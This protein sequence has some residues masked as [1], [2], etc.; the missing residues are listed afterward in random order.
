MKILVVAAVPNELK[1]IKE[2]IKSAGLKKNLNIDYLCCGIWNYETISSLERYLAENIEPVFIF[3][4]WICGYWSQD[5]E[6]KSEPIQVASV[7]NIYT[8]KELIIPPFLQLASLKTCF[9]WENLFFKKTRSDIV[10]WNINN[11]VYFDT[12]SWWI[13]FVASKYKYPYL[14]LKISFNFMSEDEEK[15]D[16]SELSN[17]ISES[18]IGLSYCDYL[19]KILYWMKSL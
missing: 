14:I 5:Y 7:I 9:S 16:Y 15:L 11:D 8:E 2:W 3:N 19:Q 6:K 13:A 1:V 17:E 4:I 18:L 10:I 12:G